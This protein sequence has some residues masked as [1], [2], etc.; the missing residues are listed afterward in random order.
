MVSNIYHA[1]MNK[2]A[3][4]F[5]ERFRREKEGYVSIERPMLAKLTCPIHLL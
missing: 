2:A 5:L 4:C 1:S 3:L